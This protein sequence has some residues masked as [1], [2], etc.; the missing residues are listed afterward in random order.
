MGGDVSFSP[1]SVHFLRLFALF[2]LGSV[3]PL[4]LPI[5]PLLLNLFLLLYQLRLPRLLTLHKLLPH[6]PLLRLRLPRP[7][8]LLLHRRLY[9][10][11]QRPA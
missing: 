9:A 2:Y 1:L 10:W 8:H 7:L 3:Q 6:L 4:L 11:V 5:P